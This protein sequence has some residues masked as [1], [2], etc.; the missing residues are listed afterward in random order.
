MSTPQNYARVVDGVVVETTT[1]DLPGYLPC[2]WAVV[3][4]WTHD[5]NEFIA[6]PVVGVWSTFD[7][8]K[9]FTLQERAA[10]RASTHPLIQDFMDLL[11]AAGEVR[12]D[13][14]DT[15]AGMALLVAE[16]C[17]TEA[18]KNEILTP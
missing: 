11:R 14:D 4:G 3:A 5:G 16:G 7:F 13:H 12:G 1:R 6:P 17:I 18:R 10:C 15:L 8:L 2:A 9:R